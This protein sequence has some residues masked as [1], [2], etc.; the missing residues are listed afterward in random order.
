MF[1][2]KSMGPTTLVYPTPV[3]VVGTYDRNDKANVMTAAWGGICSSEPPS[4]AIS[5]RK[6]RYTY[7][8]IIDRK[9]FTISIPSEKFVKE[10]DYFGIVSGKKEDKFENTGLTPIPSK[11]VDA[12]YVGEFPLVLEC[13]VT[14]VTD[15][16]SHT[17]FVGEIKDVKVNE[18]CLDEEGIPDVAKIMPFWYSPSDHSYYAMGMNLGEGYKA[19]SIFRLKKPKECSPTVGRGCDPE[20]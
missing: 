16:G 9:A 15:L 7:G 19:G 5:I 1:M 18:D 12:P 8:N 14:H 20:G 17:Q 6:V 13:R 4:V 3:F 11:I 2:K 10:S